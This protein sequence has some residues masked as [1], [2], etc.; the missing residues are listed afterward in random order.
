MMVAL[1]WSIMPLFCRCFFFKPPSIM[2]WKAIFEVKRSSM[3][4][5]CL[6]GK[7]VASCW[8]KGSIILADSEGVLSMCLGCPTRKM[9]TDSFWQ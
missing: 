2:A 7:A 1:T 6:S 4:A 3:R 9:S 5:I 8:T